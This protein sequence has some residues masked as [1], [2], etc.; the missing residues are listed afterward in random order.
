MKISVVVPC[1][2]ASAW[3]QPALQSIADQ[4]HPATEVI[5]VDD[6]SKDHSASIARHTGIPNRVISVAY[7]NAAAARNVGI[8][9]ATGDWV[10]FLDADNRWHR[11]HLAVATSTL[12]QGD[13][14]L[15]VVPPKAAGAPDDGRTAPRAGFPV[16][17]AV[18]GL[19][20]DNLVEWL[21]RTAWGF[22]TSGLVASRAR[23]QHIG[24]FDATQHR[25][26]D[27]DLVLRLVNGHSWSASPLAT[28]WSRPPRD[29]DISADGPACRYYM[30]RALVRN[31]PAYR[32]PAYLQLLAT[33]ARKA[34]RVAI[35]ARNM[36]MVRAI[37]ELAAQHLPRPERILLS[38]AGIVLGTGTTDASN[39]SAALPA[40][41]LLAP[42][43]WVV[44]K[45]S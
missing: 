23:L 16:P 12:T 45:F 41:Q 17:A 6:S 3:L 18:T 22:P 32:S 39:G 29:G 2:N 1:H 19:T 7:R 42:F 25:R 11:D 40:R 26:H 44:R 20:A 10:A 35:R 33:E 15:F 36:A 24:G 14:C 8:E 9:V 28:W 5:V 43:A 31:L 21:L 34:M 13:D 38:T 27:F 30:L 37:I 4:T